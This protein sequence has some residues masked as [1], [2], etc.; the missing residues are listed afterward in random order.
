LFFIILWL[1]L[2]TT[3]S[4]FFRSNFADFGFDYLNHRAYLPFIVLPFLYYKVDNLILDKEKYY[5]LNI[6]QYI[7]ILFIV[8]EIILTFQFI[9]SYKNPISFY[10]K[11]CESQNNAFAR[12][13]LS[14]FLLGIW[15]F[16]FFKIYNPNDLE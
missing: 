8:F 9:D 11:A 3:P 6:L 16:R 14:N 15:K 2:F 12:F 10:T 4:L 7:P 13:N 1:L 5:Y